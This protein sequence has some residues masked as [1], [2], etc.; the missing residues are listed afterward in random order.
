MIAVF[1]GDYPLKLIVQCLYLPERLLKH[2]LCIHPLVLDKQVVRGLLFDLG[3]VLN[4]ALLFIIAFVLF[5]GELADH[6]LSVQLLLV[7]V[8]L[9]LDLDGVHGD[10]IQWVG[11]DRRFHTFCSRAL[12]GLRSWLEK[13]GGWRILDS[14]CRIGVRPFS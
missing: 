13:F 5:H 4:L 1:I 3:D 14:G 7:K 2:V 6:G 8:Y 10:V 11:R 12:D 9:S